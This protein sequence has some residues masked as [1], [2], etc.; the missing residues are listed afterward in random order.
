MVLWYNYFCDSRAA[1]VLKSDLGM[2]PIIKRSTR[3][4]FDFIQSNPS[5][6]LSAPNHLLEVLVHK[7]LV[8]IL[9]TQKPSRE[10]MGGP[11]DYSLL[12]AMTTSDGK[13]KAPANLNIYCSRAQYCCRVIVIHC[14]RL[15]D[16]N[17]DYQSFVQHIGHVEDPVTVLSAPS[18]SAE[19][20]SPSPNLYQFLLSD[21]PLGQNI[22]ESSDLPETLQVDLDDLDDS[23][24]NDHEGDGRS[25][26]ESDAMDDYDLWA[27]FAPR[28]QESFSNPMQT[29][30]DDERSLPQALSNTL[31]CDSLLVSACVFHVSRRPLT[32][33]LI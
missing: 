20:D 13:F 1:F 25:N 18:T 33:I 10:P 9:T 24:T 2:T 32:L 21:E 17:V 31:E 6:S 5:P 3:A 19:K 15:G 30:Q 26:G 23:E 7:L 28:P 8:D 14:A 4:L 12:L 27:N 29:L 16:L 11:F 22:S